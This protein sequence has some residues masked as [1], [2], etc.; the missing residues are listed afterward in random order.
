MNILVLN[1][2]PSYFTALFG[3]FFVFIYTL[4]FCTIC[5][6][7]DSCFCRILAHSMLI[8]NEI[9][10]APN[11]TSKYHMFHQ[12]VIQ[13]I[14]CT[15][16]STIY[17]NYLHV[18]AICCKCKCVLLMSVCL[19]VKVCTTVTYFLMLNFSKFIQFIWV[20]KLFV[21]FHAMNSPMVWLL[22]Y[23]SNA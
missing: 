13:I 10:E 15:H 7:L 17:Y 1:D 16:F 18:N 21:I 12:L 5:W 14:F 19:W 22:W 11:K 6:C 3:M 9:S 4:L 20:I 2:A 8:F 23:K